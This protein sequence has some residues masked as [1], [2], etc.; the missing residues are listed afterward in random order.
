MEN[1]KNGTFQPLSV[2]FILETVN[3]RGNSST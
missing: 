2:K 1:L 3:D